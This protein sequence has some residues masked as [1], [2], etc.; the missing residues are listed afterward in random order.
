[1]LRPLELG[2]SVLTLLAIKIRFQHRQIF[3]FLMLDMLLEVFHD[4]PEDEIVIL[5]SDLKNLEVS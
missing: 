2:Y 4:L 3:G 1:M 5:V